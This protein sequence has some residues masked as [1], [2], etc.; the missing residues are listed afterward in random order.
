MPNERMAPLQEDHASFKG[1]SACADAMH[2][3]DENL[4]KGWKEEIDTLLL[5]VSPLLSATE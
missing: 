3:Y 4:V 2:K 5:L 1:W